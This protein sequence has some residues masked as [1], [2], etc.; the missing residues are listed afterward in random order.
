M[1]GSREKC[2]WKNEWKNWLF[3]KG[4]K[5]NHWPFAAAYNPV[6]M[7]TVI[8]SRSWVFA[9]AFVCHKFKIQTPRL[10]YVSENFCCKYNHVF[11]FLAKSLCCS[12]RLL[13]RQI[14]ILFTSQYLCCLYNHDFPSYRREMR[15]L[16]F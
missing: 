10:S 11:W 16:L 15:E 12:L 8:N 3:I 13:Q 4:E 6:L 9:T 14:Q 5:S 2:M 7:P 1:E